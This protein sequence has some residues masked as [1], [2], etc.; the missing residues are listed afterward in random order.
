MKGLQALKMMKSPLT[1]EFLTLKE[2][3]SV[4]KSGGTTQ[5]EAQDLN[6]EQIPEELLRT[7]KWY[8]GQAINEVDPYKPEDK[9]LKRM[10]RSTLAE[11]QEAFKKKVAFKKHRYKRFK[12]G[13]PFDWDKLLLGTAGFILAAS[14]VL[15]QPFRL[16]VVGSDSMV[17]ALRTGDLLLVSQNVRNVKVGDIIIYDGA[18]ALEGS[19]IVHR[20]TEVN[21]DGYVTKGDANEVEDVLPVSMEQVKFKVIIPFKGGFKPVVRVMFVVLVVLWVLADVMKGEIKDGTKRGYEA[22]SRR[23]RDAYRS[24]LVKASERFSHFRVRL[25]RECSIISRRVKQRLCAYYAKHS[26]RGTGVNEHQ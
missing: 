2:T 25:L 8:R 16:R 6:F 15:L 9:I 20:V 11:R 17:P 14:V 24:V 10:N 7:R 22:L 19:E 5:L 13:L 23:S 3:L 26:N 21:P 18:G 1:R 12:E 4:R